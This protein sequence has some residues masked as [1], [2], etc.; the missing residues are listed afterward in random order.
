M[1]I[2][3]SNSYAAKTARCAIIGIGAMGKK[4]ALMLDGGEISGHTVHDQRCLPLRLAGKKSDA[5]A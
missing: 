2:S 4:Y 5:P 3:N 1:T